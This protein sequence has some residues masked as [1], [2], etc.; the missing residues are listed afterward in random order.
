[1]TTTAVTMGKK[2]KKREREKNG[3]KERWMGK[4]GIEVTIV[5]GP[6]DAQSIVT[7][8]ALDSS[9]A[10]VL[11]LG[12]VRNNSEVGQVDRL[13]YE[14][15]VPMA[16]KRMQEI[17]EEAKRM[18]AINRVRIAHRIGE[19]GVGDVSV[20]VAVS[21]PHRAEAFDACR[22]AIERIKRYVPIWKKER[23]ANGHEVWVEGR[24]LRSARSRP[25]RPEGR[26]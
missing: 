26:S 25:S 13:D 21:S 10:T 11:F 1:M 19:L 2:K 6:I 8:V 7:N 22:Y 9:G 23:L 16:E 18:W 24:Q 5:E 20:A 15:Y 17:A 12:T 14:A 4:S 3:V